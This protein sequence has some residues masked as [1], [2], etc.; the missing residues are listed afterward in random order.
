MCI[1]DSKV[2]VHATGK[3]IPFEASC[4]VVDHGDVT[5]PAGTFK[6]FKVTCTTTIGN[7]D[8]Y[9]RSPDLGVYAVSYTHLTLPTS[10][11]V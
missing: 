5:V 7:E 6:A 8:T 11:L 1:R 10:D 9:W 3:T 4:K 2:T